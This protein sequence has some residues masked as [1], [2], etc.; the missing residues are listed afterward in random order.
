MCGHV[1]EHTYVCV[2][3][4]FYGDTVHD[5]GVGDFNFLLHSDRVADGGPFY[6]GLL[7]YLAPCP[8]D[9]VRPDLGDTHT[10][11]HRHTDTQTHSERLGS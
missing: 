1:C 7:C 2:S 5:D 9:A 4:F 11:T 3:P 8:D 6:G 10:Q